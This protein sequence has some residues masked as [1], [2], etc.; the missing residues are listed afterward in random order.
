LHIKLCVVSCLYGMRHIPYYVARHNKGLY[1]MGAQE[2]TGQHLDL[3]EGLEDCIRVDRQ[4]AIAQIY[5]KAINCIEVLNAEWGMNIENPEV[6][7]DLTG[8]CAGQAITGRS[9]ALF[10][11]LRFN[12]PLAMDNWPDFL[13]TTVPHEVAHL[14]VRAKWGYR[15]KP[16]GKEWAATMTIL[17]VPA[18]RCHVYD[19]SDHV[20]R[21]RP[22]LY[23]CDCGE[24][25][26]SSVR[27]NKMRRG[28]VYN[29]KRCKQPIRYKCKEG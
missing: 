8:A 6:R 16:H 28:K 27:H 14:G 22:Y 10:P 17:G 1:F 26:V 5:E 24:H 4:T 19:V 13:E 15:P 18:A 23:I 11:V 21:R 25:R 3:F 20:T 29:C 12:L 9:H 2:H 7:F